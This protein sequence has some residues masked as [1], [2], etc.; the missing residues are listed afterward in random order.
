MPGWQPASSKS[1]VYALEGIRIRKA[2]LKKCAQGNVKVLKTVT[3]PATD[4]KWHQVNV[5]DLWIP[6]KDMDSTLDPVWKS[7]SVRYSKTCSVCHALHPPSQFT[8]N[9]WP[10]I[11]K[12]MTPR[13]SLSKDQIAWVTKYLQYNAKDTSKAGIPL[14]CRSK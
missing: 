14:P 1:V 6:E 8:A 3:D 2:L 12:A 7:V 4:Q 13:T 11:L 10:G 9:Q 5:T